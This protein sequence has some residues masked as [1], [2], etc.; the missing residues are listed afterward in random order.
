MCPTT[1]DVPRKA[2][3]GMTL[4]EVIVLMTGV[5][6]MLGLAVL[7]LQLLLRLDVETRQRLEATAT[8]SRLASQFRQDVHSGRPE[9]SPDG[10]EKKHTGLRM[11]LGAGADHLVD[12]EASTPGKIVR[13]ESGRDGVIR[14]EVYSIPGSR[15]T[16][17]EWVELDGHP[18]G[19][20]TVDRSGDREGAGPVRHFEVLALTGKNRVLGTGDAAQGDKR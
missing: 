18:F 12:Y 8:L 7:M 20:I 4:I 6:A 17:L 9:D 16:Q 14:R 2:R 15:S 13:V 11:A 3:R 1:I 5:A 10:K 19:R